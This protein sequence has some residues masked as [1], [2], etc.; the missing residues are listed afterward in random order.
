MAKREDY[1]A[2]LEA[3]FRFARAFVA[4]EFDLRR[5]SDQIARALNVSAKTLARDV[6]RARKHQRYDEW[7]PARRG[8]KPGQNRTSPAAEAVIERTTYDAA[9][10]KPNRAKLA[11][12][13]QSDLVNAGVPQSGIQ[14]RSTIKR[15]I[16]EIE[17]RDRSFFT[18]QRHGRE[19]K[20]P[21]EVQKGGLEAERPL[22]IVQMDHQRVDHQHLYSDELRYPI[23]RGWI[24]AALDLYTGA[25]LT[26]LLLPDTPSSTSVALAMAMM[27]ISKTALLT[28]LD[29]PGT[30]E[31]AGIPEILHVDGERPFKAFALHDGAKRYGI[32]VRVEWPYSPWRKARIERFWRT[33]NSEIHSWPGTTLS[34]PQDLKQHGGA[35]EPTM[36]FAEANRR[37]LLAV[38]E[39]NHETYDGPDLPPCAEWA[40]VSQTPQLLR[41]QARDPQQYFIDLLPSEDR[42]IE[43]QGIQF[44]RCRFNDPMLAAL[45]HAGIKRTTVSFDPRNLSH[46]WVPGL[47]G[48]HIRIPRVYPRLAPVELWEL[49]QFNRKRAQDAEA[50][51]DGAL[52]AEIRAAKQRGLPNFTRDLIEEPPASPAT[53]LRRSRPPG[54]HVAGYLA[55]VSPPPPPGTTQIEKPVPMNRAPASTDGDIP[56]LKGRVK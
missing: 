6:T 46:I 1:E 3:R 45:R 14:S 32:E 54:G 7:R 39:Y 27:G 22:H 50:A 51:R 34:N 41:R 23:P 13:A 31:E 53:P 52:L 25:C 43:F 9:E 26:A 20:W 2:H 12:D 15:R 56:V 18:F 44:K 40:K 4:G 29:V 48:R 17:N 28:A 5:D 47:E 8:P 16:G 33:L 10:Q 24:A 11:R 35:R 36:T 38:M 19:G 30:W 49:G 55:D 21:L 42:D 37:L